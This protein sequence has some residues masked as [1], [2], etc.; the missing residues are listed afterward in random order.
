MDLNEGPLC[1]QCDATGKKDGEQCPY[2]RGQG[3]VQSLEQW[4]RSQPPRQT[5][6]GQT[7]GGEK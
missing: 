1:V 6:V 7:L 4:E 3:R 5:T 2:C